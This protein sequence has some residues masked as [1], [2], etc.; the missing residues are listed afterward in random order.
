MISLRELIL[1][2]AL[3]FSLW[4][5]VVSFSKVIVP[6][7]FHEWDGGAPEWMTNQTLKDLF[8]YST[9]L[10]Q[11]T[12]PS[13]PNYIGFNRGCENGAY[14]RYIV[15]HYHN[16]PDV[17][18]FVHAKPYEHQPHWLDMIKCISPNATYMS[19]NHQQIC[20]STAYWYYFDFHVL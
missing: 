6:A 7:V 9:F 20:R 11:K 18:V 12:D 16:F 3:L 19:I 8:N 14:Y 13:A 1:L 4:N 2:L 5:C 10:Y 15:D 17:A